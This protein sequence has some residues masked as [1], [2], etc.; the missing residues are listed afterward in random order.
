MSGYFIL[1]GVF[2]TLKIITATQKKSF[3]V[4]NTI[5]E[6][7]KYFILDNHNQGVSYVFE[8]V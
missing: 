1:F 7:T 5:A 8:K 6:I 3:Q 2:V 4:K